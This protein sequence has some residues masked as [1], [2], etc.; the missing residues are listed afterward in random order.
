MLSGKKIPRGIYFE[1]HILRNS[2][3]LEYFCYVYEFINKTNI[4]RKQSKHYA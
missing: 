3:L 2:K 4:V 1:Q